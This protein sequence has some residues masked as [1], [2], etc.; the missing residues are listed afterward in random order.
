MRKSKKIMLLFL[1]LVTLAMLCCLTASAWTGETINIPDPNL[2]AALIK[3]GVD[4]NGDGEISDSEAGQSY[5]LD[6]SNSGIKDLTGMEYFTPLYNFTAT[7]NEISD[8]TPLQN[9]TELQTLVLRDNKISD[10]SPLS[11]IQNLKTILIDYNFISDLKPFV[12]LKNLDYLSIQN[13]L[14][15]TGAARGTDSET[16]KNLNAI[17]GTVYGAYNQRLVYDETKLSK[18]APTYKVLVAVVSEIDATSKISGG[19]T[20]QSKYKMSDEEIAAIKAH[21]YEFEKYVEKCTDYKLNIEVDFY[22]TTKKLTKIYAPAAAYGIYNYNVFAPDVP[23]LEPMVNS[24]DTTITVC[25]LNR[26]AHSS[27]GVAC[28]GWDSEYTNKYYNRGVVFVPWDVYTYDPVNE[29]TVEHANELCYNT[30]IDTFVHEFTHTLEQYA[31]VLGYNNIEEFHKALSEYTPQDDSISPF[32]KYL[33]GKSYDGNLTGVPAI[34]LNTPPTTYTPPSQETPTPE[35]PTTEYV[36]PKKVT[37]LKVSE[38]GSDYVKLT[39]GKSSNADGY[40]VYVYENG[41]SKAKITK[42]VKSSSI[43]IT[44]LSANTKYSFSVKPYKYYKTDKVYSYGTA[45]SKVTTRTGP[46]KVTNLKASKIYA[47]TVTLTWTKSKNASGYEISKYNSSTKKW[48]KVK[49]TKETSLKIS[50]LS[51]ATTYK[52]KVRA[53]KT[54]DGKKYYSNAVTL[55]VSTKPAAPTISSV[56][57]SGTKMTVEM[58]KVTRAKGYQIQVSTSKDFKKIY[59]T[60]NSKNKSVTVK[61]LKKGQKYYIRVRAYYEVN[62]KKVYSSY[63]TYKSAK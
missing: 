6:I 28:F 5:V 21:A 39:W 19:E 17:S 7:N 44:S 16:L 22:V 48:E 12:S 38:Q 62:G 9:L 55:S 60:V 10:F 47:K 58:K 42:D 51:S 20:V 41:S 23:E 36:K 35:T 33:S 61:D 40:K 3:A 30:L 45:S 25:Y 43:K 57:R 34:V 2:K 49:T 4:T 59:K 18:N 8:L 37:N 26:K 53:Y 63:T 52:F 24:Y 56:K 14:L 13:N 29:Y 54:V 15:E 11:N 27:S 31:P 46:K 50:S 32:E 1:S